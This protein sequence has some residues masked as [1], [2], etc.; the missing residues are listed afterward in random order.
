MGA[1][2]T[3]NELDR[4]LIKSGKNGYSILRKEW[5]DAKQVKKNGGEHFALI[6]KINPPKSFIDFVGS[7]VGSKENK[8]LFNVKN[9]Q[10]PK[11][12]ALLKRI[13]EISTKENDLVMDF[14]AGSGTTLA[15]AHKMGRR[16]IG[17]EQMDYIESITKE[18]LKKV[19]NGEQGG[20]SKALEWK[21]G[22]GFV[23]AELMPLNILYKEKIENSKDE[24]ELEKIYQDL[25]SKA[26]LDY[27]VDLQEVLKDREFQTLALEE[28]KEVLK[29]IL[30]SNMDYLPYGEI[31]DCTYEISQETIALNEIF[32]GGKK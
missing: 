22:G 20:V 3:L 26:F 13:I 17:I 8:T 21:G 16:W 1:G 27:R 31:K 10:N 11:P 24:K 6:D 25:E 5:L 30:D 18:R 32:Y 15:V 23:Y 12:E 2:K 19:L 28:K 4:I 9:F 14:F 7:G 29:L